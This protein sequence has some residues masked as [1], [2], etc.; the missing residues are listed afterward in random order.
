MKI[1]IKP[2]PN[3]KFYRL[4][5][6]QAALVAMKVAREYSSDGQPDWSLFKE[7]TDAHMARNRT[8]NITL[9]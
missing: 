8:K 6:K 7:W 3:Q 4:S 2:K 5:Y 9:L 1:L